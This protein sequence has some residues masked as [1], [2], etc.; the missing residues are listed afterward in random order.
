MHD[1]TF[2]TMKVVILLE[3]KVRILK[4]ITAPEQVVF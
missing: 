4:R 2:R 1:R 3:L